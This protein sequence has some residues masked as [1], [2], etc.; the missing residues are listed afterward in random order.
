MFGNIRIG[1]RLILIV[2]AMFFGM[3]AVGAAALVNLR[4]NLLRDREVQ[5]R[6]IVESAVSII[7]EF[8][9]RLPKGE[10]T[11]EELKRNALRSINAL[12][13]EEG[14]YVFVIDNQGTFIAHPTWSGQNHLADKDAN[15]VTFVQSFIDAA[16]KGGDYVHYLWKRDPQKSG[17]AKISYILPFKPWGWAVG[18][19]IYI[20]DVDAVFIENASIV[21]GISFVLFLLIGGAALAIGRGITVPLGQI[22]D[23]MDR[24]ARGDKSIAVTHAEN[25]DEIGE[26]ARALE[27]FKLNAIKMEQLEHD[28]IEQ[29]KRAAADRRAMMNKMADDFE[30][31]VKGIV[32]TVSSAATEM[33]SSAQSMATIAD[34]TGRQ[35][36][37][38]AAAAEQA[39]SNIQTVA[40]ASEE[41]NASISEISRQIGDSVRAVT[42]CV[43]DA[44]TSNGAMQELS[45]SAEDIGTV[46]KLIEGIASQVNLLALN[47]TIE[48]ARAGEAGR[49]FAVV[50]TEVKNLAGQV[51][52]AAQNITQQ[53]SGIQNQTSN[54]VGRIQSITTNVRQVNEISTAIAAAVEEQGTATKEISRSI[55]ETAAGTNEVTRNISG[56]TRAAIETGTASGQLL[57]TAGQLAKE[58]ENLRRVVE[59]F[60][61][62]VREG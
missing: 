52:H 9:E 62:H 44:D 19:G 1:K 42:V 14:N 26:L 36:Q 6:I 20:D 33:E 28:Q 48:A 57:G 46:V 15:G 17:I 41:L 25:R 10:F 31:S 59:D 3:V 8:Y 30:R 39:S 43:S 54:A 24:L 29:E 35:A 32:N 34:G 49:G 53:I 22:T 38:V 56:M 27:T 37:A 7:N 58:S 13:Y 47:A 16:Q 12:R 11:E 21:G 18:T 5:T 2:V 55:Q 45:K 61:A 40:S 50:A 23:S 51:G 4:E 60:I